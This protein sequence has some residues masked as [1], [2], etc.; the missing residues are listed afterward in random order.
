MSNC[1]N[2]FKIFLLLIAFAT[3]LPFKA[4]AYNLS[5]TFDDL[6]DADIA[7]RVE[8]GKKLFKANC[9]ACHKV[10]GKL[11]GPAMADVWTHWDSQAKLI[12]WVQNSQELVKSGDPY[13]VKIFNEYNKQVMSAFTQLSD[14]QV[15]SI[16]EYYV[17]AEQKGLGKAKEAVAAGGGAESSG[18]S[19]GP[20]KW[21]LFTVIGALALI[22]ISLFAIT[23]KLDGLV[24]QGADGEPVKQESLFSKFQ[25]KKLVSI[26]II[27]GV[28]FLGYNIVKGAIDLGRSQGYQPEQPIK[29]SHALH[30]GQNKIDCQYCH[31]GADKSRHSVI[32]SMAV[33]MNCHKY[34]QEGPKYGETEIAKIYE[35]SGWDPV[36]SSF[37]NAPKPIEWVK[38]HNLPDHVYFNHSQHVKVGGI[39]CQTCHGNVQEMEVVQQFAPLSMGW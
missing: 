4:Q 17:Q 38:I 20:N 9:A 26:L 21:I 14:D 18:P 12:K 10:D 11:T 5:V 33:C 39:E 27:V 37:K 7:A 23:S 24:H 3:I 22:A 28:V 30:A 1:R 15:I 32:P 8:E 25:T 29:F 13:A 36:S 34:V 19:S 2:G 6:S 16:V 35:Y 31:T